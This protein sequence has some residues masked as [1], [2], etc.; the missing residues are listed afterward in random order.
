MP[1][2]G[3]DFKKLDLSNE[4]GQKKFDQLSQ[5]K[6]EVIVGAAQDEAV[7]V[8][9]R[10]M[11]YYKRGYR[12]SYIYNRASKEI[13][14][15]QWI[16]EN[17][18]R[19]KEIEI[20]FRKFY[21]ID[22]IVN[23]FPNRSN[24]KEVTYRRFCEELFKSEKRMEESFMEHDDAAEILKNTYQKIAEFEMKKMDSDKFVYAD[25]HWDK[26]KQF[27]YVDKKEE[28]K[29]Q[30]NSNAL[31]IVNGDAVAFYPRV[32]L[33]S[34]GNEKI[35]SLVEQIINKSFL[36]HTIEGWGKQVDHELGFRDI[37]SAIKGG[38]FKTESCFYITPTTTE[39]G[40]ENRKKG[41][42]IYF[43]NKLIEMMTPPSEFV[44]SNIFPLYGSGIGITAQTSELSDKPTT[45]IY[46]NVRFDFYGST[47]KSS[48][49]ISHEP[50]SPDYV[51]SLLGG[52]NPK[53]SYYN[54][55]LGVILKLPPGSVS[56]YNEKGEYS[57][58]KI[59]LSSVGHT[60]QQILTNNSIILDEN[61]NIKIPMHL[62]YRCHARDN[63]DNY[64]FLPIVKITSEI[65]SGIIEYGENGE[66][67]QM[68]VPEGDNLKIYNI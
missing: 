13:K 25:R 30:D 59:D 12:G 34:K 64:C 61:K 46:S 26:F 17:E 44:E 18:L 63:K 40:S 16:K 1:E 45:Y 65:I 41:R 55:V 68:G 15:E 39:W 24:D 42:V 57:D 4:S 11:E 60:Y 28:V 23:N 27:L 52:K 29:L 47:R 35:K 37:I 31:P 32:P 67:L 53:L 33:I 56:N 9:E 49:Y 2:R 19:I 54:D 5:E 10:L 8:Q 58:T 14:E 48:E 21:P 66:V 3:F 6:K 50:G 38:D 43:N 20:K 22:N 7:E 62:L 36:C 51:I